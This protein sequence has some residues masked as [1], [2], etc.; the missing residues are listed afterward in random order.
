M[1]LGNA[2][3]VV[4]NI[5]PTQSPPFTDLEITSGLRSSS[6]V[7]RPVYSKIEIQCG[8]SFLYQICLKLLDLKQTNYCHCIAVKRVK[9]SNRFL[10]SCHDLK[11]NRLLFSSFICSLKGFGLENC[12]IRN[13]ILDHGISVSFYG[14]L[15]P[16]S[17][18]IDH[19]ICRVCFEIVR[20]MEAKGFFL[21]NT[22]LGDSISDL[23]WQINRRHQARLSYFLTCLR[24]HLFYFSSITL[25]TRVS[26]RR[27]IVLSRQSC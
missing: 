15:Q 17:S 24:R 26:Q 16:F 23:S 7:C 18:L 9:N 19:S 5:P 20:N 1:P 13:R 8:F 12:Q 14:Q 10:K 3:Y 25:A 4:F 27:G 22:P 21:S 2:L 11:W 6:S